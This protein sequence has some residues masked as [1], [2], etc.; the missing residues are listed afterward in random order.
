VRLWEGP[1]GSGYREPYG[2]GMSDFRVVI[3]GGGIAAG[4]GLLR[5]RRLAGDSVDI[6]LIAP[7]E[8]LVYR[9]MAVREPF[10]FGPA[11]RYPLRRIAQDCA[12]DWTQDSL[13][14]VDPDAQVVHTG[15]GKRV[16]YDALLIAVGAR[17]VEAYEHV[18]TFRDA[19]AD[20]SYQG[21][22]QDVEGGYSRSLAFIQPVGP[23]WPLP[24]YELAL[25]TAERAESMDIR[26]LDLALVTPEP[27][28]LA[29]FGTAVSDVVT[30]RL[31]RAG[32]KVYCNS[33]ARVPAARRL[34]IEPQGVELRDQRIITMPRIAGPAVRGLPGAGA[35]GFIPIDKHCS[36]PGTGGKVFAAGDAADYPIKHGGLGAQMADAAAAAIAVLAGAQTKAAAFS[37]VIRG[38]LLTGRDPVFM[39]AHPVGAES[40]ESEVFDSPP[41]PSD[42]K[43]VAEELGPYL[44]GLDAAARSGTVITSAHGGTRTR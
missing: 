20:A 16:E 15:E 14:W 34:L 24:L 17:H 4:E 40:F 30:S 22:V 33:L 11:R 12:A 21:I 1:D 38:K 29:V 39:R 5:L 7:N 3:C 6:E 32:I 8:E 23:V 28:P 41:W 43:V 26:D 35:H 37:P 31:A 10:A 27:R 36:V 9:P 13:A 19:E 18:A 25:M 42:E 2:L 44:T